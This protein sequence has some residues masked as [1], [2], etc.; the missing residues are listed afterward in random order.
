MTFFSKQRVLRHMT[1]GHFD[2]RH[3][4]FHMVT[5]YFDDRHRSDPFKRSNGFIALRHRVP[6]SKLLYSIYQ[7]N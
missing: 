6:Y 7:L 3:E 2:H 5:D 4:S 1:L